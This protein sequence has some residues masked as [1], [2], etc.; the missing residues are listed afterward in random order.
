MLAGAPGYSKLQWRAKSVKVIIRVKLPL[1]AVSLTQSPHKK[2]SQ[3]I[4]CSINLS[5]SSC[6]PILGIHS[7]PTYQIGWQRRQSFQFPP[8]KGCG[9][10]NVTDGLVRDGFR[11]SSWWAGFGDG[12]MLEGPRPY[13]SGI[14]GCALHVPGPPPTP[15]P[16]VWSPTVLAA[17]VVVLVLVLPSTSTT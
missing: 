6:E 15:T 4:L 7:P 10:S 2:S 3:T 1:W 17:T 12:M 5:Q 9:T 8:C 11:V 16:M 14:Y 13:L